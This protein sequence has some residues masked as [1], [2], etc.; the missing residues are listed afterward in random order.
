MLQMRRWSVAFMAI[1]AAFALGFYVGKASDAAKPGSTVT[2]SRYETAT[3]TNTD[4]SEEYKWY[5]VVK[6]IDGDT[7]T[8]AMEGE[9]VTVRLIG[10]DTPETVDP[11]TTVQCF[12]KEAS[13]KAK[14]ILSG[15]SV[16][17]E[18]DPSQGERDKYGRLLAYAFLPSGMNVAEYLIIEGYGHEYTYN[19]PYK[20]QADFKA[21][22]DRART[23]ERGLW[24]GA[25]ANTAPNDRDTISI[26]PA[27]NDGRY[28]CSRNTYN[29]G[30]F[31]TQAEAQS[32]F[33]T[34]GGSA[35]DVH[36][37]DADLDGRVCE[38]LP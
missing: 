16:R 33:E 17:I 23:E 1:G 6:V 9:N 13:E 3:T 25:C 21:A 8:I 35:N 28:E 4:I 20:Y 32:A 27:A 7:F 18:L 2:T 14:H 29:C 34:C 24:A 26:V 12:G 22:E 38:S 5:P 30:D 31:A 11:R 10:L 15:T 36:K 37:L 19:L